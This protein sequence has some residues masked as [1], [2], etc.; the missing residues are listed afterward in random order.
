MKVFDVEVG[1]G[2]G[3]FLVM[4]GTLEMAIKKVVIARKREYPGQIFKPI[5]VAA[6]MLD[7]RGIR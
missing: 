1:E 2:G 5:V 6:K 4:A 7:G 3:H